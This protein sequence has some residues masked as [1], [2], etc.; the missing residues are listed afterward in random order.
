MTLLLFI[1]KNRE[2]M[3][4]LYGT[5]PLSNIII[6]FPFLAVRHFTCK[7]IRNSQ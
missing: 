7:R 4:M 5:R 3:F 1:E 6:G 2:V